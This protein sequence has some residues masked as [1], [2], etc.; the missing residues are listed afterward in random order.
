ML[1][2]L[3]RMPVALATSLSGVDQGGGVF[4]VSPPVAAMVRALGGGASALP[5]NARYEEDGAGA[6]TVVRYEEDGVTIRLTEE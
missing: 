6:A 4:D 1:V 3:G 5:A 2:T